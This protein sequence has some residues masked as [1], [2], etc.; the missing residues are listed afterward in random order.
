VPRV[1]AAVLTFAIGIALSEVAAPMPGPQPSV[2]LFDAS[3]S[4][5]WNRLYATLFIREDAEGNRYGED[6]LDPLFWL[7]TEHLLAQ[8]SHQRAIDILNEFLRTHAEAL[9]HD[10]VKKALLQRDLWALFDWTVTQYSAN[11]RPQYEKE[12]R[13][14]QVRLA[15]VLRRLGLTP[16]ELKALPDNYA[17]A[18]ASGT[19]GK[20][21][22]PARREQPFLPPDLFDPR[23]PWVCLTSNSEFDL[24]GAARTHVFNFSGRSSFLVFVRLPGG[25]KATTDYLQTLWNFPQPWVQR[26]SIATDQVVENPD[27]PSFPAGTQFALVRRMTVIDSRGDLAVSPITESMQFRF[28]RAITTARQHDT[29]GGP[30]VMTRNSGQDFFEVR[31]SRPLL[32]AGENAGLRAV[33][34]EEKEFS[35]FQQHGDDLIDEH[36]RGS[37]WARNMRPVLQTCAV[38]HSG[39]GVLSFNSLHSVLRPNWRQEQPGDANYGPVYWGDSATLAWKRNHYDWGLL[40]GYWK[41]AEPPGPVRF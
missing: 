11:D 17:Q 3:P 8:P 38:C 10:P 4:H 14:L 28:Y 1:A 24:P 7:Q 40:N 2:S 27:L 35:T 5:I 36:S 33:A 26:P 23:G 29:T 16:E 6:S 41:A 18:V 15:E 13:E 22:D 19:F 32:F 12:K 30:E 31:M 25:R 21:Y 37:S 34:R 39:G 20:E 9:V